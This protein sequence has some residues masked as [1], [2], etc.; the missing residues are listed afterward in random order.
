[1][2]DT[3][4]TMAVL[5]PKEKFILDT[6][7]FISNEFKSL[8]NMIKDDAVECIDNGLEKFIKPGLTVHIFT[9]DDKEFYVNSKKLKNNRLR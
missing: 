5:I 7:K 6:N 4:S 9:Y 3:D 2:T 1:M 8:K